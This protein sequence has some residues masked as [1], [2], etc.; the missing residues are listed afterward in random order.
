MSKLNAK[1]KF[2]QFYEK[3]FC[4]LL[5]LPINVYCYYYILLISVIYCSTIHVYF[6]IYLWSYHIVHNNLYVYIQKKKNYVI[7]LVEWI[8]Y[9]LVIEYT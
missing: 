4:I 3:P 5:F 6:I 1:F 2:N 7:V 8:E 9:I